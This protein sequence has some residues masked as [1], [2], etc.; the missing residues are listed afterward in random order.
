MD[1]P[2]GGPPPGADGGFDDGFDD[3]GPPP[4]GESRLRAHYSETSC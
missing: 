4:G 2:P 3:M 1:M